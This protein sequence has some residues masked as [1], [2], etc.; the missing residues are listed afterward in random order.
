[1]ENRFWLILYTRHGLGTEA[2]AARLLDFLDQSKGISQ[3]GYFDKNEPV[4]K[5]LNAKT[6][7][8]AVAMLSG[9]PKYKLGSMML[10]SKDSA[11]LADLKWHSTKTAKWLIEFS[12]A[13]YADPAG[14]QSLIDFCSRLC[15][16]F[17]AL[18]GGCAP[19]EDWNA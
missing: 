8:A 16:A 2:E 18:A 4:R 3:P 14:W 17:P 19:Y 6:L 13:A 15:R 7:P 11:F 1:M 5:V 12:G 9:A 10:R